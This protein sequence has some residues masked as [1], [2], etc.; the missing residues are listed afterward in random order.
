MRHDAMILHD[1]L[2]LSAPAGA[3]G[4]FV[5][6]LWTTTAVTAA[7]EVVA[8]TIAPTRDARHNG[9]IRPPLSNQ[10]PGATRPSVLVSPQSYRTSPSPGSNK[11]DAIRGAAVVAALVLTVR[12]V[13]T[14]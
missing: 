8:A 13:A 3:P 7:V 9:H 6:T 1:G 11:C 10:L 4:S 14:G 12:P 2:L 5:R